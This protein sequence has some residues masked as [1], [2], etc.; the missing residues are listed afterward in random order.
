MLIDGWLATGDLARINGAGALEIV[1]RIKE[2]VIKNGFNVY[3]PEVEAALL[4]LPEIIQAA[5]IGQAVPGNE[6]IIAFVQTSA[7]RLDLGWVNQ[8]LRSTLAG[9]KLLDEIRVVD[10]LPSA[11]SGKIL[12]HRLAD[13]L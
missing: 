4:K 12:K 13:L 10:Q 11:P 2:L 3:P 8:Q 9:Y 7:S 1:G 5:V 6:R